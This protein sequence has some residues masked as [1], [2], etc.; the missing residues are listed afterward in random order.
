MRRRRP[1]RMAQDRSRRVF[2]GPRL[3][4]AGSLLAVLVLIGASA[5]GAGT[6]TL[7][8]LSTSS[9]GVKAEIGVLPGFAV[10][11]DGSRVAS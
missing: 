1:G 2:S 7:T 4:L 6:G 11:D 3:T 9:T 8:L 5:A 10:S